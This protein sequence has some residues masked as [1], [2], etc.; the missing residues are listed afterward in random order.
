MKARHLTL[1][2]AVLGLGLG[3]AAFAQTDRSPGTAPGA[4]TPPAATDQTGPATSPPSMGDKG[5]GSGGMGSG[6]SGMPG[7]STTM[8]AAPDATGGAMAGV[9][10]K[11]LIGADLKNAENKKVGEVQAVQLDAAGK[12]R[13]LIVGVGVGGFMGLGERAVAVAPSALTV[14]DGGDTLR[15]TLTEDQLKAMPEYE[16]SDKNL[17][18]KLFNDSGAVAK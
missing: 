2:A 4:G 15:T 13:N 16:Y 3:G 6:T 11:E 12:V 10:A 5:M 7:S 8:S 9:D 17:R 1:T 14:A 18:G